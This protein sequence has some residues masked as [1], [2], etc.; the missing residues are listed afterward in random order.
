MVYY[1]QVCATSAKGR[2]ERAGISGTTAEI[3]MTVDEYLTVSVHARG[4]DV[5]NGLKH[6]WF[7]VS[8]TTITNIFNLFTR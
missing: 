5:K 2:G 6:S 1:S 4:F 3:G 7:C 8:S